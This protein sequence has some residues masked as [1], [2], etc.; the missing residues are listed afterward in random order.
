MLGLLEN[1]YP[2]T[3]S[4]LSIVTSQHDTTVASPEFSGIKHYSQELEEVDNGPEQADKALYTEIIP[5]PS[6]GAI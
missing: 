5:A 6:N 3:L 2:L 1:E 4:I